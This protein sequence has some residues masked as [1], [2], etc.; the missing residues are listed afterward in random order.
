M[1]NRVR[2]IKHAQREAHLYR[3]IS[4]LFVRLVYDEPSLAQVSI[5]RVS[6]S[7]D[8]SVCTVYF[9]SAD[10]VSDF[11]SKLHTIILYKPSLR[12]ALSKILHGRYV[13]DLIFKYD[14][15]FE[16]Q[17]KVEDLIDKLKSEGKL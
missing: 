14:E 5:N 4:N 13:P 9:Y 15:K 7:P 11:Q 10:G 16:K 17:K 1:T 8:R 6:L 12:T 3:E 2:E